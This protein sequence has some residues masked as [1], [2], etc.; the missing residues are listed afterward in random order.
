MQ[1]LIEMLCIV[2]IKKVAVRA[3]KWLLN[4]A[5]EKLLAQNKVKRLD[6]KSAKEG[7]EE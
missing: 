2:A 5:M 7:E 3:V 6:A 4:A 1:E